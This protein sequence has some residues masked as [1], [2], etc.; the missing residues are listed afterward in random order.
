MNRPLL[1]IV[2]TLTVERVLQILDY[3]R[4]VQIQTT[5]DF[6]FL[7]TT[8]LKKSWLTKHCATHSLLIA[9]TA[10]R[11]WPIKVRADIRAGRATLIMPY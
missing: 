4:Y 10:S 11:E 6:V 1:N 9:G 7:V 2:H 5:E 3:A 8:K